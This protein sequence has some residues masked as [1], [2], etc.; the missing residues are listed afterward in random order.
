MSVKAVA[1]A[2]GLLLCSAAIPTVVRADP[3]NETAKP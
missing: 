3:A 2:L 1:L